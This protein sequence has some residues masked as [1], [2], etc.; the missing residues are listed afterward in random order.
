MTNLENMLHNWNKTTE[1]LNDKIEKSKAEVLEE[2]IINTKM[3]DALR[4]ALNI[5]FLIT[6]QP[7]DVVTPKNVDVTFSVNTIGTVDSYQ[8]YYDRLD[9][10]GWARVT[11][12]GTSPSYTTTSATLRNGWLFKCTITSGSYTLDSDNAAIIYDD[13]PSTQSL[14][15]D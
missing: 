11:K 3:V 8:W 14:D 9:G 5:P 13:V 15:E 1:I 2:T 10:A 6:D 7:K 12:D 4:K